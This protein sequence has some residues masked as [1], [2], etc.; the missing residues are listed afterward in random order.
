MP[1]VHAAPA[2]EPHVGPPW[3]MSTKMRPAFAG[4]DVACAKNKRLPVVVC[5]WREGRPV[6]EPLA[7][8]PFAPPVSRGNAATCD[9]RAVEGFAAEAA[10]YLRR[11]EGRPGVRLV[12]IGIDAPSAPRRYVMRRR[13]AETPLGEAGIRYVETPGEAD[14][15]ALRKNEG[16]GGARPGRRRTGSTSARSTAATSTERP[17]GG[18]PDPTREPTPP[19]EDEGACST[20]GVTPRRAPSRCS[21]P[22]S[23]RAAAAAVT[24]SRRAQGSRLIASGDLLV[25][26]GKTCIGQGGGYASAPSRAERG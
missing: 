24:P 11:I 8:L 3:A 17:T 19:D 21:S 26:S 10:E 1:A 12:R 6:P 7:R 2:A 23:R 4:V 20:S 9:P 16:S 25:D 5:R 18:E 14:F 15:R 13:A 22:P